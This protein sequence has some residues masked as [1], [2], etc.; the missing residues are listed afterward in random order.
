MSISHITDIIF[1]IGVSE[2]T[3][4]TKIMIV[5][6]RYSIVF[7]SFFRQFVN[8]I[9]NVELQTLSVK[10]DAMLECEM[11]YCQK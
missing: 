6:T 8:C 2:R 5:Q 7:F 1:V 3:F 11:N 4:Y 10:S 9:L